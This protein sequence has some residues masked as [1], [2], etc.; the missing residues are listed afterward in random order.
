MRLPVPVQ[1]N[2][3]D[4]VMLSPEFINRL[5]YS[6]HPLVYLLLPFSWIYKIF[7]IL[8]RIGYAAGLLPVKRV[9]VPVI[10]VGNITVGGTGKTPLVIWLAG[11]LRDNGYR[12]A[13]ISRGYR[14]TA[15]NWPQQVR[16]DSDPFM[17][18]DE[19]VVIARQTHCPVAASPNRYAAA[20]QLL[21]HT[22]ANILICDD[23][24]QHHSLERDLEIAVVDSLR[25]FGNGKCL[26]AGPLRESLRRL[27]TVDMIVSSGTAARGEFPME[28]VPDRLFSVNGKIPSQSPTAWK[29]KTVH[30]V[31]G[32]GHPEKFFNMLRSL[33]IDVIRHEFPDHHRF[34]SVDI[35]FEDE[36][37]VI[38]TEKDAVKCASFADSR[39][40]YLTINV[41]MSN[42]FEHR[43]LTLLRE[44]IDGQKA[45]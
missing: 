26:P 30:A 22:D 3:D 15:S 20:V 25:R 9:S 28:Y 45:A 41:I 35:H 39:H 19:P 14:G 4:D 1:I 43:L 40:W 18:G 2:L 38:M 36:L 23:G 10:I 5:W 21:Q 37:P 44:R 11:F 42:V 13:I 8:R 32:I 31:A 7:M 33:D 34:E 17:V 16:P 29:G 12:P 6:D 27:N 24:L